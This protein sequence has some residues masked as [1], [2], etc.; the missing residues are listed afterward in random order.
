MY[1]HLRTIVIT[2]IVSL[3]FFPQYIKHIKDHIA[4]KGGLFASY[5]CR[6]ECLVPLSSICLQSQICSSDR[7]FRAVILASPV[8][9][10]TGNRRIYGDWISYLS[11]NLLIWTSDKTNISFPTSKTIYKCT[12]NHS[13]SHCFFNTNQFQGIMKTRAAIKEWCTGFT[14]PQYAIPVVQL[15]TGFIWTDFIT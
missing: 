4:Q 3:Y 15:Y 8:H 13:I 1:F 5:K 2:P 10:L 14:S 11:F 6:H 12:F 9:F 7:W